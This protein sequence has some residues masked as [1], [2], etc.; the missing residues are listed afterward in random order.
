MVS[1]PPQQRYSF[2]VVLKTGARFKDLGEDDLFAVLGSVQIF[3]SPP[4]RPLPSNSERALDAP[5]DDYWG[6]SKTPTT[7]STR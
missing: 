5:D 1:T 6:Q 4:P 7:L 2:K 3:H